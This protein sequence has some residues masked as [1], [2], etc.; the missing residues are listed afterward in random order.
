MKVGDRVR[1]K[2][3]SAWHGIIVGVYSTHMTESGFCVESEREPGSVQLYP[4]AAL[5]LYEGG[6]E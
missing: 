4:E 5:E 1:K 2:K 3:G 6:D